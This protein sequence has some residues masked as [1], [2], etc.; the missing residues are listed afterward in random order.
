MSASLPLAQVQDAVGHGVG[1]PDGVAV[2]PALAAVRVLV[3]GRQA[4]LR[5]WVGWMDHTYTRVGERLM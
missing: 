4:H 3:D 5:P 2:V 1:L